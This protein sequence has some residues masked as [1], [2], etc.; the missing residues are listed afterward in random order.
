L[1][2]PENA[3]STLSMCLSSQ[4]SWLCRDCAPLLLVH[5]PFSGSTARTTPPKTVTTVPKLWPT[6]DEISTFGASGIE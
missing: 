2:R 6:V 4:Q 1:C 3:I 5:G